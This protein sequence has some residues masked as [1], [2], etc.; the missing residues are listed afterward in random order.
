MI[1]DFSSKESP[2]PVSR[3]KRP[4]SSSPSIFSPPIVPLAG[5]D[6]DFPSQPSTPPAPARV[7]Q[8]KRHQGPSVDNNNSIVAENGD[9]QAPSQRNIPV[10]LDKL[11]SMVNDPSTDDMIHW[12]EDGTSFIVQGREEFAK[13]VLPQF[14]KHNTFASFVRQLNMYHFHK[15]PH[16]RQGALISDSTH[17]VWEFSNPHFQRGRPGLLSVVARKRNRDR[18]SERKVDLTNIVEDIQDIR[19]NQASISSELHSLREDNKILW[20]ES[21]LAREKHQEHQE[22]IG[23]I[24]Q[25]LMTAFAKNDSNTSKQAVPIFYSSFLG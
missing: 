13:V 19:R 6:D 18:G 20:D 22:V 15:I 25:F 5:N 17:E 23:K 2:S 10:F 11:Y 7:R 1:H 3:R 24:L 12:S 21:F 9:C 16:I 4:R 14:Y 8:K